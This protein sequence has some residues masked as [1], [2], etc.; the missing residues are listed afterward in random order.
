MSLRRFTDPR[1]LAAMAR[2]SK[3]QPEVY[4]AYLLAWLTLIGLVVLVLFPLFDAAVG[5]IL[6]VVL[7]GVYIGAKWYFGKNDI[8]TA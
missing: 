7:L 1:Q 5:I 4:L 2:E 3:S 6:I 8:F